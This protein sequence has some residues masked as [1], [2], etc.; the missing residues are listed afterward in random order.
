VA[1]KRRNSMNPNAALTTR[2]GFRPDATFP[3][4]L[5]V[6]GVLVLT[7]PLQGIQGFAPV[8]MATQPDHHGPGSL[9]SVG[10]PHR[11][12][13]GPAKKTTAR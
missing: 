13:T 6:V 9:T 12:E 7:E 4:W 3:Q 8:G 2:L 10:A 11:G 1:K 5:A